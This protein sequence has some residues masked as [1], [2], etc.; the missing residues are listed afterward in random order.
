MSFRQLIARF[1]KEPDSLTGKTLLL[2]AA[3]FI[4]MAVNI[5]TPFVLVRILSEHEFGVYG[6]AFLVVTSVHELVGLNFGNAAA[7]F[8]PRKELDEDRVLATILGF[9]LTI[10]VFALII[11]VV[12]PEPMVWI[13][14]SQDVKP[15]LPL[16]G[17]TVFLW[18]IS[19]AM[20]L[21]PIALGKSAVSASFIAV[22]ESSKSLFVLIPA[23]IW[24]GVE[25]VLW[26]FLIWSALRSMVAL[27]YFHGRMKLRLNQFNFATFKRML[28][29]AGPHA[30][31]GI[32]VIIFNKYHQFLVTH[33]FDEA[34][35]AVYRNGVMQLPFILVLLDSANSVLIPEV[36]RRQAAGSRDQIIEMTAR[37]FVR[38]ATFFLPAIVLLEIFATEFITVLFTDTYLES[39]PIFRVNLLQLLCLLVIMDPIMRGYEELK[40]FRFKV[41][42]ALL[43]ILF[44]LGKPTVTQYGPI[45]ATWLT[46]LALALGQF[47]SALKIRSL[48]DIGWRHLRLLSDM[49]YSICGCLG[50]AASSVAVRESM[51]R[52]A[53]FTESVEGILHPLVIL[54]AGGLAFGVVCWLLFEGGPRFDRTRAMIGGLRGRS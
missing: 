53:W 48:L 46:L 32:V 27:H 24:P 39:V 41:F 9:N 49:K 44:V 43:V 7:F 30:L 3:R 15:L 14:G 28:T 2:T 22:T 35:Y 8:I 13:A 18:N 34:T 33:F 6:I 4:S 25:S 23:L 19:R 31:T 45:G 51:L 20:A 52:W 12:F 11:T 54:I 40:L 29:Y 21:V 36:A 37:V 10:G 38:L 47:I 42:G 5:V 16:I 50:G 17:A 26:G 1:A